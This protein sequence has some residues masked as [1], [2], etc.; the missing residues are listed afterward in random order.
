MLSY[1]CRNGWS[2]KVWSWP[3]T[4]TSRWM[5]TR[6]RRGGRASHPLRKGLDMMTPYSASCSTMGRF[7]RKFYKYFSLHDIGTTHGRLIGKL[8]N[9]YFDVDVTKLRKTFTEN[10]QTFMRDSKRLRP[11]ENALRH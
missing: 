7:L 1:S 6:R 3:R 10:Y 4:K 2:L 5:R 9:T 8:H 11:L